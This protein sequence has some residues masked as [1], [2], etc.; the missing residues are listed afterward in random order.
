MFHTGSANGFWVSS[1]EVV[2]GERSDDDDETDQKEDL[3]CLMM[4]DIL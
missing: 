4:R 2:A 1:G 3:F